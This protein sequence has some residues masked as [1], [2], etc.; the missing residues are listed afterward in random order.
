MAQDHPQP[1]TPLPPAPLAGLRI[2]ELGDFISAP[3]CAR[4]LADCGADVIKVEPPTGDRSRHWGPF[5]NDIPDPEQSGLFLYCN[6]GKRSITANLEH[7]KGCALVERLLSWADVLVS[8]FPP[9]QMVRWGFSPQALQERYPHLIVT[10]VLPYGW[11]SPYCDH[12][13]TPMTTFVASGVASRIGTQDEGPLVIPLS[14]ADYIGGISAAGATMLAVLARAVTGRGQHVDVAIVDTLAA[15]LMREVPEWQVTGEYKRRTG[16]TFIPFNSTFFC[17]DGS[18]HL[19]THRQD[20]WEAL[21]DMMGHPPWANR[22]ELA[23]FEARRSASAETVDL[24]E[25][26][27]QAWAAD[28]TRQELFNEA[29]RRGLNLGIY[30]TAPEVLALEHLQVREA[31][32]TV[33][34]GEGTPVRVPSPP[35]KMSATPPRHARRAPRLGEHTA[36]VLCGVLGYQRQDLPLLRRMGA[37]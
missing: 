29:R 22:P 4:L 37:I 24:W 36:E 32:T 28:Y 27:V 1:D 10:T 12:H 14:V 26:M 11:D 9:R 33:S 21:M 35:Y 5:P 30:H 13:A 7:P 2:L 19:I 18:F 3:Y 16:R 8:N 20:W 34:T 25:A 15:T 23:T 17:R 6:L 31:F